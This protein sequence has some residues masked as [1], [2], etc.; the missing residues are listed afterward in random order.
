MNRK[1]K[2]GFT[3]IELMVV[4]SILIILAGLTMTG[5]DKAKTATL[6][7]NTQQ[8]CNSLRDGVLEYWRDCRAMPLDEKG[9]SLFSGSGWENNLLKEGKTPPYVNYSLDEDSDAFLDAWQEAIHFRLVGR[10]QS[11]EDYF[12]APVQL[13]QAFFIW[14]NGPDAVDNFSSEHTGWNI[15][16]GAGSSAWKNFSQVSDIPNLSNVYGI[17]DIVSGH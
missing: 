8:M 1:R 10:I 2:T 17:D 11:K 5:L 6:A 15:T 9:R 13:K 7:A 14:S 16:V 12:L 4:I 3:L